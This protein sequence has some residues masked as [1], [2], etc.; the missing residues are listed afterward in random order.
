VNGRKGRTAAVALASL[1]VLSVLA[2]GLP[3]TASGVAA[4]SG[5]ATTPRLV[6]L[7]GEVPRI[8]SD[9]RR[10]G[11]AA[12][13]HRLQ[14][15]VTLAGRNPAGLA[16]AVLA[17]SSP[18]S[19]DYHHYLSAAQYAAEFG[20]SPAER[21]AVSRALR[22]EGLTVGTPRRGS[23]L[24]PVSGTAATIERGF[25]TSLESVRLPDHLTSLVNLSAPHVPA[26]L[27]GAIASVVGLDG[28]S[29]AHDLLRQGPQVPV[30]ATST[31]TAHAVTAHSVPQPCSQAAQEAGSTG[32]TSTQL[33][34]DYGLAQLETQGRTGLGETI[35]L[36]EFEQFSMTDIDDFEACYGLDNPIQVIDID[37][38]PGGSATGVGEAALDIELAAVNAP[39]SS[40]LVYE[41]PP[42][43]GDIG[44]LDMY[45]RIASDD[46]A[47]TVSTSW[48]GCE[49]EADGGQVAAENTIFS[50]MAMQGQ[51]MVAAA[52]D[53]GSEDCYDGAGN[54]EA[55]ESLGV[56]DPGSQ[57]DVLSLG[58]TSLAGGD[59]TTQTVWNNCVG[60]SLGSCQSN[61][62]HGAGGG[63]FS[64]L[65]RTPTWQPSNGSGM[66]SVPDV[67]GSAD[68]DHGIAIVYAGA[69]RTFGGTSDVAPTMAGLFADTD[70]GC[71]STL[72]LVG[73][74]LYANDTAANFTDITSGSNDF[75]NTNGGDYTAGAG[76]DEASGLGTPVDQNLAIALQGHDGCPAVATL[77]S[78]SG[79]VTG[80]SPITIS[81]GGLADA[82]AVH[83]GEAGLGT[84]TSATETSLT[85]TPPSVLG[86]V[87][88]DITVT[89]PDGTSATW[90]GDI[91]NVGGSGGCTPTAIPT[92]TGLDVTSGPAAGGTSVTLTG[93]NFSTAAGTDVVD[94][95]ALPAT[96]V[97][98]STTT[99]CSAT[100]PA[101]SQTVNVTLTTAAGT[102]SVANADQFTYA[103]ATSGSSGGSSPTTGITPPTRNSPAIGS[104]SPTSG[105]PAGG[106]VVTIS[107]I[108]LFTTTGATTVSFGSAAGSDVS[109]SSTT[110]CTATSPAGTGQ[111]TVTVTTDV[112]TSGGAGAGFTYEA[113]SSGGSSGTGTPTMGTTPSSGY[114]LVASDGGV[115]SFG[116]A[117]FYGSTGGL[118]LNA[119]IVGMAPT[120]D[121]GGYWLVASDGGIFA[122]GDAGFYG[123]TGGRHLNAPVVAMA[124]TPDGQGY[125]LVAADGGIFSFGDATFFGSTGELHLDAPIV[126]M[127]AT[128]N[129]LGYWLVAA[130]GG[131]FDFGDAGFF[132]STGG[133]PLVAPIVGLAPTAGGGGYWL[134]DADGDVFDYGDAANYGSAT[135]AA[136]AS[137][138]GLVPAADGKGYLVLTKNGGVFA[139]GDAAFRGSEGDT[140]LARPMVGG[141]MVST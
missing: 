1:S 124:A 123:S 40:I 19:P 79:P 75:L 90:S 6:A 86:P 56:D 94:F 118:H 112:G 21:M 27:A 45:Q 51:T 100:S 50:Q 20:P 72:G 113:A 3:T 137:V 97:T 93:T 117:G 101:G 59:L 23:A 52:G 135:S 138:V 107:G 136:P 4:A 61:A 125:W 17:V 80:G 89:N 14:L 16:H 15:S 109:C 122:F 11:P 119:P 38:N 33:S 65:W 104:I 7:A 106:T 134:A 64:S 82:T 131:I 129:G 10:L 54:T 29:Q 120:P 41:A 84:I 74:A 28:L 18:D 95:G 91:Y 128:A 63:G 121:A 68:P 102:S 9:V 62:G 115:F 49:A 30:P 44:L 73:P 60:E 31:P 116:S 43:G 26:A 111:V 66:R 42:T 34:G 67:A 141:A 114:W 69:W 58:G 32:Y 70:Q 76:Y 88:V 96:D 139:Y 57:P 92:L 5:G 98:C 71:T 105:P 37:G 81:G 78:D 2:L 133:Y 46:V 53:Q 55:G 83:F 110:S 8:P 103:A 12:S 47:Q 39:S 127:A 24:L 36:V 22:H 35:G 13:S 87:C 126:G 108:N 132:G 99:N 130:D 25:D 77:S 140:R 85:V 48:G